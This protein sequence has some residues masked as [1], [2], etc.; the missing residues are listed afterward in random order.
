MP[1]AGQ[2]GLQSDRLRLLRA[3][4]AHAGMGY[5]PLPYGTLNPKAFKGDNA[6]ISKSAIAYRAQR[7]RWT[8]QELKAIYSH[9]LQMP[10]RA[11]TTLWKEVT[12]ADIQAQYPL[13]PH[14][15][16]RAAPTKHTN[17]PQRP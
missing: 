15:P 13:A 7:H 8:H 2:T 4:A 3:A 9:L 10:N 12:Y 16:Q 5:G 1:A 6:V 14:A 11:T 17:L